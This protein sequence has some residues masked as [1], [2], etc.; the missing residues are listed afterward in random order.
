MGETLNQ[1][2]ERGIPVISALADHFKVPEEAIR[3]M[4]T[5]GKVSFNDFEAAMNSLA[6][7]GGK[8]GNAMA[9]QADTL[10][11]KW[12]TFKDAIDDL[13]R[14]IGQA[15]I[16]VMKDLLDV[17][18][19]VVEWIQGLDMDTVKFT[20]SVI[21]AVAAFGLTI[22]IITKIIKAVREFIT[23]LKALA[24]AK[25]TATAFSGP[26]GWAV[27]AG[28]GAAA[29]AATVG[30]N[31]AFESIEKNANSAASEVD[32]LASS[33]D[34]IEAATPQTKTIGDVAEE[35]TEKLKKE[36]EQVERLSKALDIISSRPTVSAAIRGTS[37]AAS[38]R[39]A[40]IRSLEKHLHQQVKAQDKSNEW[41]KKIETNTGSK[42]SV[43]AF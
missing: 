41:L 9:E 19:V 14:E 32:N 30:I 21:A 11:G 28:A 33:T 37:Q 8:F 39:T 36:T 16:P 38:A 13:K 31:K 2:S 1:L 24:A 15:L 23:V 34:K 29:T 27:L 10:K 18:F 22:K 6:G 17:G 43:A 20:A 35:N 42:A 7:E 26:M 25:A 3:E 40:A 5:K 12:S 4:V